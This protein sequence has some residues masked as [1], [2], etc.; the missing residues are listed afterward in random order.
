MLS[1]SGPPSRHQARRCPTGPLLRQGYVV[2]WHHRYYDPIRQSREHPRPCLAA[3]VGGL[4]LAGPFLLWG[5]HH[6]PWVPPPYAGA[7]ADCIGP[8]PSSTPIGLR[9]CGNGLGCS[10]PHDPFLVGSHFDAVV[11]ALAA[12]P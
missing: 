9:P 2:P 1:M 7:D 6:F 4:T 11:F 12:A 5:L 10:K 8:L 3:C